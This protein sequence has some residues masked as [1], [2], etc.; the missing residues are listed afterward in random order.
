MNE[1]F[2]NAVNSVAFTWGTQKTY[3]AAQFGYGPLNIETKYPDVPFRQGR[4]IAGSAIGGGLGAAA[5][6]V[7]GGPLAMP[8][9]IYGVGSLGGDLGQKMDDRAREAEV[10]RQRALNARLRDNDYLDQPSDHETQ[11][12]DFLEDPFEEG[13]VGPEVW[14][15]EDERNL[16]HLLESGA[17]DRFYP[18]GDPLMVKRYRLAQAGNFAG[19]SRRL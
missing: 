17:L 3:H 4:S 19:A 11:L 2:S 14:T 12:P 1:H 13:D 10:N 18:G 9:G 8:L 5:G 7:A 16:H 6:L 15:D